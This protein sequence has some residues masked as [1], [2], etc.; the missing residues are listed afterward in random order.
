M[1]VEQLMKKRT[2]HAQKLYT[3]QYSGTPFVRPPLL[4]QKSDLSRGVASHQR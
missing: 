1:T 4:H 2:S 3:Y